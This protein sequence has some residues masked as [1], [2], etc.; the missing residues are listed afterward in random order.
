MK[1]LIFLL[2]LSSSHLLAQV[3]KV[4]M[5]GNGV[6]DRFEYRKNG[7]IVQVDEDRNQDS[8]IDF[9]RLYQPNKKI[10]EI[11]QRDTN[12]DGK[13]D[14]VVQFSKLDKNKSLISTKVDKDFDGQFEINY[15]NIIDRQQHKNT[16]NNLKECV[17]ELEHA[18]DV[19]EFIDENLHLVSESENGFIPI[20]GGFKVDI[21]CIEKWGDDFPSIVQQSFKNGLQ[22]LQKLYTNPTI[23]FNNAMSIARD[24]ISSA[25]TEETSIVCSHENPI[26]G[27]TGTAALASTSE[28][29]SL[30]SPKVSHPYIAINPSYPKNPILDILTF[31]Y[32]ET[33]DLY[34]TLFHERIHNTGAKHGSSIEAPYAC[35]QCCDIKD[36]DLESLDIDSSACKICRGEYESVASLEYI[37]DLIDFSKENSVSYYTLNTT[38]K[39]Y[40]RE[41]PNSPEGAIAYIEVLEKNHSDVASELSKLI[42]EKNGS[43]FN[44]TQKNQLQ[45]KIQSVPK[46]AKTLVESVAKAKYALYFEH[47]A[48]KS[49]ITLW[50]EKEKIQKEIATLKAS[51]WPGKIDLGYN[52]EELI[53]DLLIDVW[54]T[55]TPFVEVDEEVSDGAWMLE[56]YFFPK[57]D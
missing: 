22:C 6:F 36:G 37:N 25:N 2:I 24:L 19:L 35:E 13:F 52:T 21:Q 20:G 26:G 45:K 33:S 4:D 23:K 11:H 44:K 30:D 54:H 40:L 39:N 57:D 3:N 9:R 34:S 31:G 17:K 55:T 38:I 56:N 7:K 1:R 27:W 51:F 12:F 42:L 16:P 53:D 10:Y 28:N 48:R 8:K 15:S 50:E 43:S 18:V 41:N 29:D 32:T 14:R 49:M 47:D 5:T 46:D